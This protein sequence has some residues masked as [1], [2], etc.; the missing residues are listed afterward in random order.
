MELFF[1]LVDNANDEDVEA[2]NQAEAVAEPH[3]NVVEQDARD[4]PHEDTQGENELHSQRDA[5]CVVRLENIHGLRNLTDGHGDTCDGGGDGGY[6]HKK[7]FLL[8]FGRQSYCF[9]LTLASVL[10]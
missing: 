8:L 3:G 7:R 10:C 2:E 4:E 6:V 9:F 1:C 5:L